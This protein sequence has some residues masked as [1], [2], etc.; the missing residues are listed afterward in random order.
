S[1]VRL[2]FSCFS[3]GIDCFSFALP[4]TLSCQYNAPFVSSTV[5]FSRISPAARILAG[6]RRYVTTNA[7]T[8]STLFLIF[9]KNLFV[10]TA[11]FR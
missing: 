6:N 9:T 5:Q 1:F 8:L 7:A 2:R 10:S 4:L 11:F 3:S